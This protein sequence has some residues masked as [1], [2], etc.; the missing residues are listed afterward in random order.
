MY[1][2]NFF[3]EQ[4]SVNQDLVL[5]EEQTKFCCSSSARVKLT[6]F[7][8]FELDNTWPHTN[9]CVT[10]LQK[11]VC[12]HDGVQITSPSPQTPPFSPEMQKYAFCPSTIALSQSLTLI[13][14]VVVCFE[15]VEQKT[16]KGIQPQHLGCYYGCVRIEF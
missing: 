8:A 5:S 12:R 3:F 2:H 15:T 4:S 13:H 6:T 14:L 11:S 1:E 16:T 10:I 9:C 7:V